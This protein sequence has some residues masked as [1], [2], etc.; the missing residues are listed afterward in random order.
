M[1]VELRKKKSLKGKA[2]LNLVEL[3]AQ[4]SFVHEGWFPIIDV[5]QKT[6]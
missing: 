2:Q 6:N 5:K 4:D 1:S 3:H